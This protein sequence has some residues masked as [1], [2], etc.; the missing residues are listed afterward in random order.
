MVPY[1]SSSSAQ[2]SVESEVGSQ[3]QLPIKGVNVVIS[4]QCGIFRLSETLIMQ[5]ELYAANLC[6]SAVVFIV[7][8]KKK[9]KSAVFAVK[10][11][12]CLV[13]FKTNPSKLRD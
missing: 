9:K 10:L 2:V 1:G 5:E 8:K 12:K 4:N 7:F 3:A 13:D 11:K 6:F